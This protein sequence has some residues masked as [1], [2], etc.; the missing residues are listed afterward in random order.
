MKVHTVKSLFTGIIAVCLFSLLSFGSSAGGLAAIRKQPSNELPNKTFFSSLVTLRPISSILTADGP[1]VTTDKSDYPIGATV[2]IGGSGW[3]P[4]ETVTLQVTDNLSPTDPNEVAHAPWD[5]VADADG[6]IS[7]TWKVDEDADGLTLTLTAHGHS[8][9]SD[10]STNFTDANP[11]ANLDQ[12]GNDPLPSSHLDGCAS[13]ASD[14]VNGNLGASKSVYVEGDSIPYRMRFGNLQLSSNTVTIEWDTTKSDKHAIDYITTFNRTVADADPCLGVSGCNSGVFS[15]LAIPADPQ[16]TGAG[17]TPIAGDFRL[18]GGTIT[19][20]SAYSYADGTGFTGDKSARITITFVPSVDNPVLAWGGHIATRQDWGLANSAV[21]IPGSPYHTRL[22]D[23]NGSGGNQDR[24]LSADAVIFPA[25]V[26]IIKDAVPNDPQDFNFTAT[27]GLTPSTFILDDDADGTH[28]N[29]QLYSNI[30]VTDQNGNDYTLTE[31]A[32]SG[33]VLSFGSPPC[34]VTSPNGGSQSVATNG[35]DI[36]LREGENVTCVFTNTEDFNQTRGRIIVVKEVPG[37]GDTTQFTFNPSANFPNPDSTFTAPF[38]LTDGQSKDS[39]VGSNCLVAGVYSVSETDNSA[40]TTTSSCDDGSPVTAIDVSE[41]ETVTCTFTN[42]RNTGNLKLS[43]SLTGGPAGYT[44]PFTIAYDCDDGTAHDGNV[45]IAS[46]ASSTIS[47]IPTGTSC[48][49]SETPPTPPTGYS[50]GTPTFSPSATVAITTNGATVEVTTNN[51]LTRDTGSLKLSKSLTGGPAGYT[52]PFTIAYDCDDGTAHDGSVS[53]ASGA[54]STISGIPVGTSC[55][56]SE[57]PPTAPTGYTFGTPTFSPQATVTITP[58]GATVEVTTNNTL[59]RDTGSLKLSKALTGGPA[60]YTGPF[61]IAYDCDDGTAHDGSVSIASGA[62]STISGIPTGTSCTVSETPPA[63]PTGYTFGTPTFSPSATVTITVKDATVEVTTNNTLTR[64]TGSL[65]LAKALT[66]GPAGYTGPFT[67]GYDCDDGTAHD[68]TVSVAS[69]ASSTISGIPTGTSCTVS[70]TPP[71][72][73]TGYTFGTPTFSPQATVTITTKGATVT[74][75]TNNTLTRDTGSLKLSKALTGGPAGYTGPFTIAYDCDD[76]TTHDGTVSVASGASSTISGIPTGTQCTVSETPPTAPTGYTFGTPTFSPSATVTITTKG[77]TVEV[78][79]NNTLTRDRGTFTIAKTTNNPD[80]ATL[81][82]FTMNYDCGLDTDGSA[83]TGQKVIASGNS[84]TVSGIPTGNTCSV[85]EVAP[86]VI[87]GYTWGTPTYTPASIIISTTNGTFT[88]TVGNSITRDLGNLKLSK[89]LTGGP[90]GYTGPFTIAYDCD[91]GTA[92][93]GTKSVSAGGYATVYGIPTGTHCTVSE[94]PPTPPTG[95][96]FGTPTFSPS[97]TVTITTKG[98]TVEV[99][100]NNTLTRDLG[101]LQIKK[102]LSNPDGASVPASFTVNYNCG[103]AYTGQVSVAPGSPATVNGIPTGNTCSVTE[104]APAAIANYTWGTITYSPASVVISTKGGTFCITVG[105]SIT[106]DRGTIVVIKN[107]KPAQGSFAFTTTSTGTGSGYNPFTLTGATTNDGNKNS[108][109]LP[110]GDYTVKEG[111]QL[112]WILTG[113]GGAPDPNPYN[114]VVTG[115]GGSTG[116]GNLGTM[117][118]SITLKKGDT[119]TC[120]FENTGNGA[121]RTQGFWA[122]HS[123]LANIAWF[124]G[125]AFGHTFPGVAGVGGIGDRTLCGRPID[126]LGKLMGG[127]W[128]GV[129]NTSTGKKRSALDQARMQLLQQ[130]LSA[131]LNSSAFGSAPGSGSFTA[132]ESAYC[133]TNQNAIQTALQQSAS[134]NNSGD[135]S[136]FTPGTSA[137]SKNARAI[138]TYTFW[139]ILP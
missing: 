69:G 3:Q 137:D 54:S 126:T 52:G 85:T 87:T 1:T 100:T 62:S 15:T 26:T 116:V 109:T 27:G 74:V 43:K 77:A 8:S 84:T 31:T 4:G 10:A 131:E 19:A 95:Y 51:T 42:T 125:T 56:V 57:T 106:R 103:T 111:T 40:Y 105:N 28:S 45:S 20:V 127:F 80:G 121:T 108:Q 64:D 24:S 11:S 93:D 124:G 107:A 34:T 33:W 104:V 115:S 66:G 76:G 89:S 83:L 55:T 119:V 120:T 133:G 96:T 68:G 46:G 30:L 134:F 7:S 86:D 41:G 130:L 139:D 6:N 32:V 44:G 129:S 12:C 123:P 25:T 72:A 49:I 97:A 118:A 91:D 90:A 94:T 114:C 73:P 132:W 13:N 112:G 78:T 128:S 36:N 18:Y 99:T 61:T 53:V 50:F 59:T 37:T 16:V 60:G 9:G 70:E 117:T 113:I 48:T 138:A 92:H 2:V 98:A 135:S 5:V 29:T 21:S 79:T 102:T 110:T 17:V 65:E 22:I 88:I 75:T 71:T 122:T 58:K 81:P 82:S 35:I 23:L 38:N 39:C 136:T 14:W 47:G 63:P 67:I 101:S